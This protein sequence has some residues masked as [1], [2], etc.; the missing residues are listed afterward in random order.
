MVASVP[1]RS[2]HPFSTLPMKT[3]SLFDL[4]PG[5]TLVERYKILRTNR[6]GGMATT[7]AVE[8]RESG[9]TLEMQ[10]FPSAL[11]ESSRQSSEFAESL[12]RWKDLHASSV[13]AARD[14]HSIEDGTILYL[15]D[16][17]PGRSLRERLQE[18][19]RA[20]SKETLAIGRQ[21]LDEL[22]A[23]HGAG[24]VHG[25][26][27][28]HTIHV[29]ESKGLRVTLV[30]GGI[31]RALWS[32][33]HLGDK[34][35]LI[36]T[37]YYAP[38]EQFGGESPDVQSDLYNL[39]TVLYQLVSGAMPWKGKTFL[40]VFQSKLAKS[41]PPMRN[42]APEVEVQSDLEAAI[43]V[44]LMA[45]RSLRYKTAAEFKARLAAVKSI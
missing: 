8:D 19:P 3:I 41:P 40:E 31:T 11:F 16:L 23:I 2:P 36:G 1:G 27:K 44:G 13:L 4:A 7:F 9:Q 24:L 39:A 35:A 45:D 25:D 6:H 38:V 15:T 20:T 28:P 32:A 5:K 14:V 12:A 26:I 43:S 18:K 10:V 29:E 17:P 33:K 34:T 22:A 30:D 42:L 21:L 37:P